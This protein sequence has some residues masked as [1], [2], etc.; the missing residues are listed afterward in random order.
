MPSAPVTDTA[1]P[2]RTDAEKAAAAQ[3]EQARMARGRRSTI[4][5]GANPTVGSLGGDN[6]KLGSNTVLGGGANSVGQGF[7]NNMF[8]PG[9]T[10]DGLNGANPMSKY[11]L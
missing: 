9:L 10:G 11:L 4:I 2:D 5:A 3:R 6:A 8:K 1:P 7:D